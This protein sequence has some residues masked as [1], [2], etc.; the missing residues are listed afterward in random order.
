MTHRLAS[1]PAGARS[2]RGPRRGPT[3]ARPPPCSLPMACPVHGERHW[4][5]LRQQPASNE[6]GDE[7]CVIAFTADTALEEDTALRPREFHVAG[8]AS[9]G[10]GQCSRC[11][12]SR[13]QRWQ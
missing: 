6:K 10:P 12:F 9:W 1:G 5:F 11:F 7:P 4:R 8:S 13:P 3:S 2:R